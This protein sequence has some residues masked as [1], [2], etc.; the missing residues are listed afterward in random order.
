MFWE[1]RGRTWFAQVP[2]VLLDHALLSQALLLKNVAFHQERVVGLERM[3][4]GTT[5]PWQVK[6]VGHRV[7]ARAVI[8]ADGVF[9]TVRRILTGRRLPS[10][11]Y[12]RCVGCE[13]RSA[14]AG[15]EAHI[16][17]RWSGVTGYGWC[18]PS[19]NGYTFGLGTAGHPRLPLRAA[20]N[21][22]HAELRRREILPETHTIARTYGAG[23]PL[24][25]TRWRAA[26]GVVLCGDAMGA[27]RQT[28]GEGIYYAM[29]TGKAA[30]RTL[31]EEMPPTR[32]HYAATLQPVLRDLRFWPL[33][34]PVW[35]VRA[36]TFLLLL[37]LR[38]RIRAGRPAR[39]Q[40]ALLR[41]LSGESPRCRT[42]HTHD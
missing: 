34:V 1:L 37:G 6:T 39:W 12:A 29:Q 5:H 18:F 13:V 24:Q 27:V 20:L 23:V 31:R 42:G 25:L 33:T 3:D 26:D 8:G 4:G 28:S 10:A 21:A 32:R 2:R 15:R 36:V 11:A 22:L 19:A 41:Y 40:W 16:F 38:L 9:S 14:P 35:V 30:A 17:H 7:R